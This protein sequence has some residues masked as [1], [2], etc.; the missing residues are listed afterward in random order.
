MVVK[1]KV[2][3]LAAAAIPA[4]DQLPLVFNLE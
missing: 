4:K 3:R 2:F 1:I